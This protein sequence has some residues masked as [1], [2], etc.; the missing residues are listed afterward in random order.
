[1]RKSDN[2]I[3]FRRA[4]ENRLLDGPLYVSVIDKNQ[5]GFI[6]T[7]LINCVYQVYMTRSW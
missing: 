7:E 6:H 5:F 1:M 4:K 3:D 2:D